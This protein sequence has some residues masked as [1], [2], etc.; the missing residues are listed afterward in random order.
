M[1]RKA[2]HLCLVVCMTALVA[3]PRVVGAAMWVGGELGG[4]FT[5]NTDYNFNGQSLDG[6]P[7][8]PSVIGGI[9]LGY[10]FVNTGFGAYNWP[11]W[12]KYFSVVTDFTYNR[13]SVSHGSSGLRSLPP[14]GATINGYQAVWSFM[15]MGRYGFCPDSEVPLG[16][17]QPYI[18][19]GPAI[20]FSGLNLGS[21]APRNFV[22]GGLGSSTSTDVALVF[23]SGI[24]W[25]CLKN[26]SL[27]TA[28]RF[29]YS[30]PE[31][32]YGPYTLETKVLAQFAFLC[33]ANYHF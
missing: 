31:Y 10:D 15:L 19:L 23:E 32:T 2:A 11:K 13:L 6:T 26:V 14:H 20:V 5:M 30:C 9:T 22:G 3:L 16:R 21:A 18:G 8:K 12:M 7:M 29:R 17:V 27:D 33:R 24:R 25:M 1:R 28:F 4:N